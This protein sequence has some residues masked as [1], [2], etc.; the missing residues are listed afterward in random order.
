MPPPSKRW[1]PKQR[2][3]ARPTPD[4]ARDTRTVVG[5]ASG[6]SWH[7]CFAASRSSRV[8]CAKQ[9][10]CSGAAIRVF[11]GRVGKP[12]VAREMITYAPN[13]M[14]RRIR[15]ASAVTFSVRHDGWDVLGTTAE[16]ENIGTPSALSWPSEATAMKPAARSR[17]SNGVARLYGARTRRFDPGTA[18]PCGCAAKKRPSIYRYFPDPDQVPLTFTQAFV[19][20]HP[21]HSA[22]GIARRGLNQMLSMAASTRNLADAP[23]GTPSAGSVAKSM[24]SGS[25]GEAA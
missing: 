1:G 21:D 11:Q 16:I 20:Q 2:S 10:V 6:L 7:P 8:P 9:P 15:P 17:K 23:A 25:S 24:P 5:S 22:A 3:N 18:V 14:W 12:H 4:R 19:E 13:L